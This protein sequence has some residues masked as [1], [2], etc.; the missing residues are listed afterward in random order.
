MTTELPT[1]MDCEEVV[2]RL[3][4]YLDGALPEGERTRVL[5]HLVGCTG[6]TSHYD[7]AQAFLDAVRAAAPAVDAEFATLRTRVESSLRS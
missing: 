2:Q 7:F 6:C 1:L 4:P 3:W 5:A